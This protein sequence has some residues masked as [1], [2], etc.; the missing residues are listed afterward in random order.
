MP[1]M[2]NVK[3]KGVVNL[4]GTKEVDERHLL[5]SISLTHPVFDS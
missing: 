5:V 3:I 2:T 4:F 1:W